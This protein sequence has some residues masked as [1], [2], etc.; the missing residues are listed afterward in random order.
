M[1]AARHGS[2]AT[3]AHQCMGAFAI[4]WPS[5]FGNC[6]CTVRSPI[7]RDVEGAEVA[8]HFAPWADRPVSVPVDEPERP[9]AVLRMR[10]EPA[11]VVEADDAVRADGLMK[12]GRKSC[13]HR[14]NEWR[15]LPAEGQAK[16]RIN[17]EAGK[18]ESYRVTQDLGGSD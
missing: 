1:A 2:R 10:A 11:A 3:G 8:A 15:E 4:R 6:A 12:R 14:A 16:G 18:R 9:R 17:G 7:P 5:L 13:L